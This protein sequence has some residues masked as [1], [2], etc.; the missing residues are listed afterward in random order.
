MASHNTEKGTIPA[1][2]I[3]TPDGGPQK[4]VAIPST[5]PIFSSYTGSLIGT[6]PQH[7][8]TKTLIN[9]YKNFR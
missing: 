4:P 8:N 3:N 7:K 6:G 2:N 5:Q 1:F 9:T